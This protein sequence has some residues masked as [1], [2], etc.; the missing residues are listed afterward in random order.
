MTSNDITTPIPRIEANSKNCKFRERG[1]ASA[2]APIIIAK[3]KAMTNKNVSG[4]DVK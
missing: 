3:T 4:Y 1:V 2:A